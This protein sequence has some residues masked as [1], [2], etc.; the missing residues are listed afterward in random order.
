MLRNGLVAALALVLTLA[1]LASADVP[2][3]FTGAASTVPLDLAQVA[4]DPVFADDTT[5][6]A[7]LMSA[8]DLTPAGSFMDKLHLT[9]GGYIEAGFL[10]DLTQSKN[11]NP[12]R[13]AP[14]DNI[15]FPGPYKDEFILDQINF[16]LE[17][18]IEPSKGKFDVG[19]RLEAI[20]GRDAF[21]THS[22]GMLDE[23]NKH[24]GGPDDQFDL[25]QAYVDFALPV[26]GLSVQAG[27]FVTLLGVEL[28]DP[29]QNA[30]Y[31]HSYLFSFAIP[32]TQTGIL[33]MYT[34]NP[35]ISV[36]AG[37]TRGWNQSTDDSNGAIDFL[38]EVNWT[39]TTELRLTANLS[40]GP[41]TPG[42]NSQYWTVPEL[43]ASYQLSDQLLLTADLL[44]GNAASYSQW[45][46]AAGY[47]AYTL[48]KYATLNLRAEFYHDGHGFTTGFGGSDINYE[49]VSL[50]C[51]ITPLPDT[52][53]VDTIKIR[54]ELRAD[55]AD[56][57]VLDLS[58]GSQLTASVDIYWKF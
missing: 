3:A 52:R 14:A 19:F 29:T 32:F 24:G 23:H 36:T 15:Y 27:K 10:Y 25:L 53:F 49:E 56:R 4:F 37:A 18:I 33:G 35:N 2:E 11:L 20:Y 50:G 30:F 51:A 6:R 48:N 40:V 28:I 45:Y 16:A 26:K 5:P 31:T 13:S 54:P 42:N 38:G 47:A 44:Y 1:R 8:L 34:F 39:V 41:Q 43:I 55:F 9:L 12:P 7:P 17:R 57:P 22:N 46:G 21:F 58:H